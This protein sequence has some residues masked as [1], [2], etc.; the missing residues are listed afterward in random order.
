MYI[1]HHD[2]WKETNDRVQGLVNIDLSLSPYPPRFNSAIYVIEQKLRYQ[3]MLRKKCPAI[4]VQ[5]TEEIIKQNDRIYVFYFIFLFIM[6]F[7][8]KLKQ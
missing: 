5:Y 6:S 2:S 7:K 8:I 4:A 1:D 3:Y